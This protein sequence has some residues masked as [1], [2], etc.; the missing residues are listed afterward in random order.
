MA[1]AIT[2]LRSGNPNTIPN[3]ATWKWIHGIERDYAM[4]E[5][6]G[7]LHIKQ[8]EIYCS[9]A[10][11]DTEY[12][13]YEMDKVYNNRKYV[14]I[15]IIDRD[16]K[17]RL[18]SGSF[19]IIIRD[20]DT[21]RTIA[22]IRVDYNTDTTKDT[23]TFKTFRFWT[24]NNN[25]GNGFT[26]LAKDQTMLFG[27]VNLDHGMLE[28][29]SI[30]NMLNLEGKSPYSKLYTIYNDTT[31]AIKAGPNPTYKNES[32]KSVAVYKPVFNPK[33]RGGNIIQRIASLKGQNDA[34]VG[35]SNYFRYYVIPINTANTIPT[36]QKNLPWNSVI[37][38]EF[39]NYYP[40]DINMYISEYPNMSQKQEGVSI[41]VENQQWDLVKV[42]TYI[43][44]RKYRMKILPIQQVTRAALVTSQFHY[45]SAWDNGKYQS[46]V[47]RYDLVASTKETPIDIDGDEIELVNNEYVMKLYENESKS[48]DIYTIT[49]NNEYT[50]SIANEDICAV[51][52]NKNLITGLLRGTTI[53]TFKAQADG[54]LEGRKNL[55]V[56]VLPIPEPAINLNRKL[57]I[58][59]VDETARVSVNTTG[60]RELTYKYTVEGKCK[61]LEYT[62]YDK[63]R[64]VISGNINIKG[65]EE[66]TTTIEVQGYWNENPEEGEEPIIKEYIDVI[67]LPRGTYMLIA[68]P[69]PCKIRLRKDVDGV[70]FTATTSARYIGYEM[71][72]NPCFKDNTTFGPVVP[73]ERLTTTFT[74]LYGHLKP[75]FRGKQLLHLYGHNGDNNKVV[76]LDVLVRVLD[77]VD[78]PKDE[79]WVSVEHAQYG[80]EDNQFDNP[81]VRFFTIFKW[82][83]RKDVD[84]DVYSHTIYL[85]GRSGTLATKEMLDN[86][87][88][89]PKRYYE[90]ANPGDPNRSINPVKK[91][92]LWLN[93]ELNKIW[94]CLDN[95]PNFNLW[96]CE[97]G[98]QVGPAEKLIYPGP[99]MPGYGQGP[100][101]I[102]LHPL[103]GIEPL[104]GCY[105]SRSKEYG[106]YKDKFGNI[107]IY[108]PKFYTKL[109]GSE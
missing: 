27:Y 77:T 44:N 86:I 36:E 96:V 21:Y 50:Y 71:P 81:D 24:T 55:K 59:A 73:T 85:P 67:V 72:A 74:E 93:T 30:L 31:L 106:H 39:N 61:V 4:I 105:K 20:I 64:A 62:G 100:M 22:T 25:Y 52:K 2:I 17:V 43:K 5:L 68:S 104:P 88:K 78:V 34:P 92:S 75:L 28:E 83:E 101:S 107:Y 63:D 57:V 48:Y 109:E 3:T 53:V 95:E 8:L 80:V 69:N 42:F 82:L 66:G 108:V 60:V 49:P 65:I 14:L 70:A 23:L 47:H 51:N 91:N 13:T 19:N 29:T 26:N 45:H 41:V 40:E 18:A 10:K 16:P 54:L 6:H 58:V 102:D 56:I 11:F 46:I 32:G 98:R 76:T 89:E 37:T 15:T 103:Y 90:Y 9:D 84:K 1:D 38:L 33:V 7:N 87:N 12:V 35:V 79:I 99:G 97:D 94:R